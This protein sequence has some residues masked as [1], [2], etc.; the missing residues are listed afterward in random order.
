M[1]GAIVHFEIRATNIERAKQF[2]TAVFD[3]T[4]NSV[5]DGYWL[6]STGRAQYAQGSPI[7]IDGV[8]TLHKDGEPPKSN[9]PN[10]FVVN[11]E[12]ED[13][14]DTIVKIQQAGGTI[15]R[16]K[17]ILQGV[18]H[19]VICQDTEGNIFSVIHDD[20]LQKIVASQR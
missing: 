13:I 17:A 14:D 20:S 7:G 18:G 19:E 1:A 2:Y 9:T 8:L 11:V 15:V 3:W 5:G 12:V 4:I 16:Q 6:I 10:G